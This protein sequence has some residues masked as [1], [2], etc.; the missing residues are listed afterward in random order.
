M[1][2]PGLL[3]WLGPLLAPMLTLT[4]WGA[5]ARVAIRLEVVLALSILA[6]VVVGWIVQL[7]GGSPGSGSYGEFPADGARNAILIIGLLA[8]AMGQPVH[9]IQLND[10]AR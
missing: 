4:I 9:S 2:P 6:I 3:C 10:G 5:K 8:P 1:L 7:G